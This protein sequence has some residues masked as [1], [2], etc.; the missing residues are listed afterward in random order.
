MS[1]VRRTATSLAASAFV[2]ASIALTT[3]AVAAVAPPVPASLSNA[4]PPTGASGPQK[5]VEWSSCG[6]LQSRS[7]AATST[8]YLPNITKTLGGPGGWDT[9]FYIQNVGKTFA[10]VL[11]SFYRFSDGSLV[12][13][14][15]TRYVSG[16]EVIADD[17][18]ADL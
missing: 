7:G 3:P 13:C 17:P 2:I 12:T 10:D 8:I 11:V 14:R 6:V 5:L 4:L 18:N 15:A 9:P 1:A 16:A